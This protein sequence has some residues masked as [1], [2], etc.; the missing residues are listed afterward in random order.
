MIGA[1]PGGPRVLQQFGGLGAR[2][3]APIGA[4]S[5]VP[6]GLSNAMLLPRLPFLAA[7]REPRLRSRALLGLCTASDSNPWQRRAVSGLETLNQDYQYR[8]RP[9][10]ASKEADW[11]GKWNLMPSRHCVG[12]PQ[13]QPARATASEIVAL[14]RAVWTGA[15]VNI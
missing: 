14:Y 5:I 3:V 10:S 13:Q 12:Q 8:R 9:A 15:P 4:H 1:H 11:T 7:R 2:N 6:H